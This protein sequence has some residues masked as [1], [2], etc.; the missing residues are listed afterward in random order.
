MANFIRSGLASRLPTP[1]IYEYDYTLDNVQGMYILMKFVEGTRFFTM[2]GLARGTWKLSSLK[3]KFCDM[4]ARSGM[5]IPLGEEERS[6]A[7]VQME[8]AA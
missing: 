1:K 8:T 5:G 7:V 2:F 3:D 6:R 4:G